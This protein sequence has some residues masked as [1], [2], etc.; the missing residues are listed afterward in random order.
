MEV[1][2]E[3]STA[4]KASLWLFNESILLSMH[5]VV[6]KARWWLRAIGSA[7]WGEGSAWGVGGR[8]VACSR[9]GAGRGGAMGS[10]AVSVCNGP[11]AI[12]GLHCIGFITGIGSKSGMSGVLGMRG[13]EVLGVIGVG[14][15]VEIGICKGITDALDEGIEALFEGSGLRAIVL[16]LSWLRTG[17][18]ALAG[19][20]AGAG[21]G[22]VGQEW[23]KTLHFSHLLGFHS[24]STLMVI[25]SADRGLSISNS[26]I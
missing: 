11:V 7:S 2:A 14:N 1:S 5:L 4:E 9:I 6:S 17:T 12:F 13:K 19:V 8:A 20:G 24:Y 15:V 23:P 18:G 26:W 21:A 3:T 25:G 10:E 22:T 16:P